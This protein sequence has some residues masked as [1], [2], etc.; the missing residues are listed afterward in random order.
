M[1]SLKNKKTRTKKN[2]KTNKKS[3][4][5]T[6]RKNNKKSQRGGVGGVKGYNPTYVIPSGNGRPQNQALYGIPPQQQGPGFAAMPSQNKP[7]LSAKKSGVSSNNTIHTSHLGV[8]PGNLARVG[9]STSYE[10]SQM[11]SAPPTSSKQPS[12]PV[13]AMPVKP[14]GRRGM[15]LPAIPGASPPV[16][17][18]EGVYNTVQR[19]QVVGENGVPREITPGNHPYE[20]VIRNNGKGNPFQ[21]P[22]RRQANY[23]APLGNPATEPLYA[24]LNQNQKDYLEYYPYLIHI[25]NLSISSPVGIQTPKSYDVNSIPPEIMNDSQFWEDFRDVILKSGYEYTNNPLTNSRVIPDEVLKFLYNAENTEGKFLMDHFEGFRDSIL[26]KFPSL[27]RQGAVKKRQASPA[28][29]VLGP[30]QQTGKI[31]VRS[32]NGTTFTVPMNNSNKTKK[33]QKKRGSPVDQKVLDKVDQDYTN[34][35]N[36][37]KLNEQL[38]DTSKGLSETILGEKIK[39]MKD[40]KCF[41]ENVIPALLPQ[42]DQIKNFLGQEK[43]GKKPLNPFS[44]DKKAYTLCRNLVKAS[45]NSTV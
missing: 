15:P 17:L 41:T 10:A 22:L 26:Y 37:I 39:S 45:T 33:P 27:Q 32:G 25:I 11:F 24:T 20:E 21:F 4:R 16:A 43:C 18:S 44:K 14:P 30:S 38:Q 34:F 35:Y 5:N 1:K 29:K 2:L 23:M 8:D 12:E 3:L 9:Q 6:V 36:S 31:L 19:I 40:M 42:C 13:Y 7:K 28:N